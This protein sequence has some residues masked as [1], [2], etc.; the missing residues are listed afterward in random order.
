M[1]FCQRAATQVLKR[2][3]KIKPDGRVTENWTPTYSAPSMLAKRVCR[4]LSRSK[5][6]RS[7]GQMKADPSGRQAQRILKLCDV[8]RTV[9]LHN[10]CTKETAQL[11]NSKGYIAFARCLALGHEER[12]IVHFPIQ[13]HGITAMFLYVSPNATWGTKQ[14]IKC[15]GFGCIN[16]IPH[17]V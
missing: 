3:L 11:K 14:G 16:G 2:S 1:T 6:T 12:S 8:T 15:T 13:N 17:Q 5:N 9:D 7:D 10:T 4:S